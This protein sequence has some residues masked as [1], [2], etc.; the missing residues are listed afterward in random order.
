MH[1]LGAL[2]VEHWALSAVSLRTLRGH[3]QTSLHFDFFASPLP[4]AAL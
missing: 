4:R 2:L 1:S 3:V